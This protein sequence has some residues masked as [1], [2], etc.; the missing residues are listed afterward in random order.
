MMKKGRTAVKTPPFFPFFDAFIYSTR[1]RSVGRAFFQKNKTQINFLLRALLQLLRVIIL[2]EKR[3]RN[4]I[5]EK[6]KKII[7]NIETFQSGVCCS[8]LSVMC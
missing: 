5:M 4:D 8:L 3:R 1:T 7:M 2:G 6:P